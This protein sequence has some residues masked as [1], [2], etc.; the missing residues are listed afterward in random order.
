MEQS[1]MQVSTSSVLLVGSAVVLAVTPTIG[2]EVCKPHLSFEEVRFSE[3]SDLQR[4]WSAVL[5][6][7]ASRCATSS[8]HFDIKLIRLK[9]MTPDLPFT[10][11]FTWTAGKTEVSLQFWLDEA[12][13]EYSIGAVA[14]CPCRDPEGDEGGSQRK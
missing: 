3:I 14:P 4:K 12:V 2:G 11:H 1:P 13:L 6:V 9:E 5:S 10:E 7:D 8:G